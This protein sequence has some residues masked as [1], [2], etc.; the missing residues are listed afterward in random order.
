MEVDVSSEL[1]ASDLRTGMV[2]T[3]PWTVV[4]ILILALKLCFWMIWHV[5]SETSWFW[6]SWCV[7]VLVLELVLVL[8]LVLARQPGRSEEEESRSGDKNNDREDSEHLHLIE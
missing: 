8:V 5:T 4:L 7:L 6:I 3:S 2:E 1:V